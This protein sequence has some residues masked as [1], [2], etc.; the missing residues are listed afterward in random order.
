[1]PL[2]LQTVH[3]LFA[4]TRCRHVSR[5]A[6]EVG[7]RSSPGL[8]AR[9][10]DHSVTRTIKILGRYRGWGASRGKTL[11]ST[12]WSQIGCGRW[13]GGKNGEKSESVKLSPRRR[14]RRFA[15][16]FKNRVTSGCCG[17]SVCG[18]RLAETSVVV[19]VVV[20]ALS[21]SALVVS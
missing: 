21:V 18:G 10:A 6:A 5:C 14:S 12:L 17:C 16:P 8:V 7:H 13:S 11:R 20:A 15:S 2:F 4:A 1:M 19:V 3:C 9:A